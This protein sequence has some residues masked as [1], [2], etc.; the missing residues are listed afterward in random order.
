[1]Y[2]FIENYIVS[3]MMLMF[4]AHVHLQKTEA[5]CNAYKCL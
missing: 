5:V 2:C 1:M 4:K 3:V